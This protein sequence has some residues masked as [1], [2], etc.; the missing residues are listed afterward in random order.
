MSS[1]HS[2]SASVRNPWEKTTPPTSSQA[3]SP[4]LSRRHHEDHL[5]AG[6][7][8]TH[9]P[10][11]RRSGRGKEGRMVP[12]RACRPGRRSGAPAV[13]HRAAG[14]AGPR[15]GAFAARG[16]VA[17]TSTATEE[18]AGAKESLKASLEELII[19]GVPKSAKNRTTIN[20]VLCLLEQQN[21]T[22]APAVSGMLNG[23]WAFKYIGGVADGPVASPTRNIA[24]LMYNGGYSPG[25]FALD[26]LTKLPAQAV[27]VQPEITLTIRADQPRGEV[28]AKVK[29]FGSQTYETKIR[30]SLEAET[31]LR[32]KEVYMDAE[33][34]GREI[35]LPAPLRFERNLYITY[36]DDELLIARDET[37]SPDVFTK[38]LA[39]EEPEQ[40]EAPA[41]E[42]PE[43]EEPVP[44]V[45]PSA[46]VEEEDE[47]GTE[48]SS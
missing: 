17:I 45:T 3:S 9:T 37:G 29:A 14:P 48:S 22:A 4:P 6:A 7:G 42:E 30:T 21:P 33:A 31:D 28:S 41:A 1:N 39:V 12:V 16:V 47:E 44:V 40:G 43:A 25:K 11:G 46:V 20:D 23:T 18:A 15:R 24:L 19:E 32:I 34:L 2:I 5:F 38:V 27:E 35:S 10:S 8:Q 13:A 26:L 36:L